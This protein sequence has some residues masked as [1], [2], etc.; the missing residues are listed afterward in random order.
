MIL[1]TLEASVM[2]NDFFLVVTDMSL[3][4]SCASVLV[5]MYTTYV[6]IFK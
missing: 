2:Q 4:Y 1:N 5:I 6:T 3:L